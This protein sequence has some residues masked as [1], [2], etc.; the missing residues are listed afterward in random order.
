MGLSVL[1]CTTG[2]IV[3]TLILVRLLRFARTLCVLFTALFPALRVV[4]FPGVTSVPRTV[5]EGE[6]FVGGQSTLVARKNEW[7]Q[8]S[9]LR[10]CASEI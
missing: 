3:T 5:P 9:V 7:F 8:D 6:S 1:M 10:P 2:I 4:L